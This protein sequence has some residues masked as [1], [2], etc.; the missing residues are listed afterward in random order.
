MKADHANIVNILY[1]QQKKSI[2]GTFVKTLLRIFTCQIMWV[3]GG[4]QDGWKEKDKTQR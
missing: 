3:G 4:E 2:T 1:C